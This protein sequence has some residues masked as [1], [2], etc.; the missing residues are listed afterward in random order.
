MGCRAIAVWSWEVS[1]QYYMA[2]I[3]WFIDRAVGFL[4]G[5]GEGSAEQYCA[6]ERSRGNSCRLIN[7]TEL[8]TKTEIFDV[9]AKA[10]EFPDYFGRNWDALD[11]CMSDLSWLSG[12]GIV[13]IV[14][15][16]SAISDD[17]PDHRVLL[18]ILLHASAHPIFPRAGT[19]GPD[20]RL[21]IILEDTATALERVRSCVEEARSAES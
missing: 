13:L 19:T 6:R 15:R 21:S 10:F 8:Q 4:S 3:E 2:E 20:R 1:V 5:D 7:A 18:S 17:S 11:E 12:D 16:S 9:F 14:L